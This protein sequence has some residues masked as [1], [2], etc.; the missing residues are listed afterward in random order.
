[1]C[2]SG[3]IN[4]RHALAREFGIVVCVCVCAFALYH[5]HDCTLTFTGMTSPL[6]EGMCISALN[7]GNCRN[8]YHAEHLEQDSLRVDYLANSSTITISWENPTNTL[9][10]SFKYIVSVIKMTTE[11]IVKETMVVFIKNS[12]PVATTSILRQYTCE[13]LNISVRIIDNFGSIYEV[14]TLPKCE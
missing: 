4:P 12:M 13:K 3:S 9:S 6:G 5:S 14:V 2:Q 7:T 8:V 10:D 1:M 11:E